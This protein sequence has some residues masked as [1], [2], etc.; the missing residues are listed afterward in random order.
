MFLAGGFG[1]ELIHGRLV[2]IEALSGG[3]DVV[4]LVLKGHQV[5]VEKVAMEFAG[6]RGR[7]PAAVGQ[8][9]QALRAL[10]NIMRCT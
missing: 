1:V 8:R 3:C 5:Q 7:V 4:A 2:E 10:I 6:T 9:F